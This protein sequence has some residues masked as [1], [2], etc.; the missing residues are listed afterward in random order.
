MQ[1][2]CEGGSIVRRGYEGGCGEVAKGIGMGDAKS[3][4]QGCE[5]GCEEV[6]R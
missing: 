6:E 2:R 3:V 5:G 4:R 1:R